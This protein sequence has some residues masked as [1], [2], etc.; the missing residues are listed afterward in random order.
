MILR[1]CCKFDM[2]AQT[3]FV[4]DAQE[5]RHPPLS[6]FTSFILNRR[7][8]RVLQLVLVY[9][10]VCLMQK[11]NTSLHLLPLREMDGAHPSC[12]WAIH[13]G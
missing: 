11:T 6:L 9:N 3:E 12:L 2:T 4:I 13:P 1:I 5:R 7:T 10:L 8:R